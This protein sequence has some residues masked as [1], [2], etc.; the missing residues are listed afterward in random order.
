MKSRSSKGFFY[1]SF[2]NFKLSKMIILRR[3]Y[4]LKIK[5]LKSYIKI[6]LALLAWKCKMFYLIKTAI[7]CSFSVVVAKKML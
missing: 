1:L 7:F 3:Y 6:S 5:M 2:E 4:I